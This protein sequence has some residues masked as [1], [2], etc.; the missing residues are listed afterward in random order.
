MPGVAAAAY[1]PESFRPAP[2]VEKPMCP[3]CR[4]PLP[5]S[6]TRPR[7]YCSTAC[8]RV[9][10]HELRRATRA[11][12][13]ADNELATARA[14]LAG[15]IRTSWLDTPESLQRAADYWQAEAAD[16]NKRLTAL[17]QDDDTAPPG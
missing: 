10:E 13:R 15:V 16:A 5:A 8:R 4:G 9:R 2:P 11:V 12:E 1:P 17:Y 7:Q 3:V 6:T 14:R